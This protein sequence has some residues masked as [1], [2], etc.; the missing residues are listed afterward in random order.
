MAVY[1]HHPSS[2]TELE[3]ICREEWETIPTRRCGKLG[4]TYPRR[5]ET[6]IAAKDASIKY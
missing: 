2:L 4:E 3:S 5:L 1:Q 6:V